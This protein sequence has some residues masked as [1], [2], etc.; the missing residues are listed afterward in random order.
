MRLSGVFGPWREW[1]DQDLIA[2]SSEFDA[3]LVAEAYL[4]GAFPMPLHDAGLPPDAMGWWSPVH[5]GILPLDDVRVTRSLRQSAKRYS[6]TVDAAFDEVIA[7]CADPS[8]PLGW[9]DEAVVGVYT[10][11][12]RLGVAHSVEAWTP[13]GDLAGGLYGVGFGG[14][15]AGE[16]MFHDPV[17]GRDASKVALLGLCEVL[18][19][20]VDG[21]LLDVQWVTGHLASLGAV[22]VDRVDYLRL[23]ADALDLPAPA[24]GAG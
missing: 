24:W 12:H 4:A 18:D 23:L 5:R 9:I 15:F 11:L 19:D 14:L 6:V 16:S 1:P 20:G 21:R 3:D 10:E 17:I 8:R 22:E 2:L 13:A 7:R